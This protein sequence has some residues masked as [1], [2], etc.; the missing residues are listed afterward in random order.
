MS[1]DSKSS[2]VLR[3]QPEPHADEGNPHHPKDH[4]K[5]IT[6]MHKK[7]NIDITKK[8]HAGRHYAAQTACVHRASTSGTKALGGWNKSRLFNSVYDRAF[9]LDTLLG[10]AMYNG[11]RPEEYTLPCSCL[12][13]WCPPSRPASCGHIWVIAD[14]AA[15]PTVPP[16]DLLTEI[17]PFIESAQAELQEHVHESSLATNITLKQFLSIL[18]WFCTVLLQD[19]AVLYS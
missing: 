3:K 9:L 11:R 12:G 6:V 13:E 15:M 19:G 17:F 1:Y 5:C 8:T 18:S 10:A 14:H 2:H 7:N 4:H 16:C